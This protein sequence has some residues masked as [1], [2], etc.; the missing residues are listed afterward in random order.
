MSIPPVGCKVR[1]TWGLLWTGQSHC[2]V[3]GFPLRA[4]A[5][6]SRGLQAIYRY[7]VNLADMDR[8][9]VRTVAVHR[10]LQGTK[11]LPNSV[12]HD[13]IKPRSRCMTLRTHVEYSNSLADSLHRLQSIAATRDTGFDFRLPKEH[14]VF[15][16][17]FTICLLTERSQHSAA[18]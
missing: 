5:A 13:S 18:D 17:L 12:C 7:V 6:F 15:A 8:H 11:C 2:R 1:L 9:K 16:Q 3:F 4:S 10:S 14:R